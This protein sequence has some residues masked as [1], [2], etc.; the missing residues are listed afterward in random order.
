MHFMR[1][2]GPQMHNLTDY[3]REMRGMETKGPW[4]NPLLD[5]PEETR[6]RRVER[7]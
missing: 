7:S 2:H 4:H 1:K 5:E 6:G 3:A